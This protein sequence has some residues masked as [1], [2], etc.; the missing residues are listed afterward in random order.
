MC[1]ILQELAYDAAAR[2]SRSAGNQLRNAASTA[3]WRGGASTTT[4]QVMPELT[5]TPGGTSS[6]WMRTGIR[7]A[8]RTHSKVGVALT[9][10]AGPFGL[11]RSVT[12]RAM[13]ST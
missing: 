3:H 4:V 12:P 1:P 5:K 7:W 11:S 10:S 6:M 2:D 13:L 9:K 8:S